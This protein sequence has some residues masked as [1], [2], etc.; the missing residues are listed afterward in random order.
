MDYRVRSFD[1]D[2]KTIETADGLS[3][4]NFQPAPLIDFTMKPDSREF[5][6]TTA[7]TLELN[8]DTAIPCQEDRSGCYLS[9]SNVVRNPYSSVPQTVFRRDTLAC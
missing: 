8:V 2:T 4:L 9:V 3:L 5:G 6:A 7:V 1:A